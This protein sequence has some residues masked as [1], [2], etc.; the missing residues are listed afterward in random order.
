MSSLTIF[1]RNKLQR[2]ASCSYPLQ[3][4]VIQ[5]LV[6]A[7]LSFETISK[8]QPQIYSWDLMASYLPQVTRLQSLCRSR[9][10]QVLSFHCQTKLLPITSREKRHE[11]GGA[12]WAKHLPFMMQIR[13][14]HLLHH[15]AR[16]P[17]TLKMH[18]EILLSVALHGHHY[19]EHLHR[20]PEP[21]QNPLR[22]TR[23]TAS[24]SRLNGLSILIAMSIETA[25]L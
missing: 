5:L 8:P 25:L 4:P 20:Q 10:T 2:T 1:S 12:S 3:S 24:S 9:G 17:K 21:A 7:S 18:D 6:D 16:R 11:R 14:P 19:N 13:S 23:R 15:Q 22:A